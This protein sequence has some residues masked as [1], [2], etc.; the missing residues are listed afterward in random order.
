MPKAKKKKGRYTVRQ[1]CTGTNRKTGE[2]CKSTRVNSEGLC[3]SHDPSR[4]A[5]RIESGRKGGSA[6][7]KVPVGKPKAMTSLQD[8]IVWSSWV[9]DQVACKRMDPRAARE[10]VNAIR[11]FQSGIEKRDLERQ[12]AELKRQVKELKTRRSA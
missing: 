11:Q 4:A 2:P 10:I 7:W 1:Q 8:C 9:A 6:T 12:A 5:A 3:L